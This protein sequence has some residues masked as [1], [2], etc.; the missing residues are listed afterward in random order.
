M[1]S[2][3][4]LLI[5][6]VIGIE[7]SSRGD[8][9]TVLEDDGKVATVTARLAGDGQEFFALERAD[10]RFELVPQARVLKREVGPD[11][12]PISCSTMIERLT[13][14]FGADRFMAH[15]DEPY[16]VGLVFSDPLP[17]AFEPKAATCLKKGA[18]FMKTVEKVFLDFVKDLKIET[19]KPRF[20]L[21]LLIFETDD[22]FIKFAEEET[23]GRGLSGGRM[24]GYYSNL[25]NRL[26]IRM[27]EC[28]T[29]ATPLHEAVHQQVYNRAVIQRLAPVPVWFNEGIA[30]GFEGN[31]EKISGGPFKVSTRFAAAAMQTKN[32]D[33]DDVVADDKAFRGD[34][35]AGE[36]Y[37]N[38]WSIHW[39]LLTKYR[40]QYVEYLKL[41]GQKETLQVETPKA[42]IDD[43]ER[44][45]GKRIGLL[46]S[47]F[48]K[49]LEQQA[50]KQKVSLV[51]EKPP[52]HLLAQIN[53]AEVE[54]TA[55]KDQALN[56]IQAGGRMRN[57][58]QI[59]PMS[60]YVTIESDSGIYAEWYLPNA[61]PRQITPM[62]KQVLAKKIRNAPAGPGRT[63]R[64]NVK[65]AVPD[66]ETGKA[67]QRGEYPVPVWKEN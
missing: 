40:K 30:T 11:P 7:R 54:I 52:G 19:Q 35:L 8:V 38:A 16:V 39:F 27:S 47:E 46:Q 20:P 56:Q 17:K 32:V 49:W 25:T 44:V 21:V 48:P 60:F 29:F 55:V 1:T 66:S 42:R 41:L 61:T 4:L 36:A 13:E 28:H 62:P 31:G 12:E 24:L 5:A 53:L 15:A 33:W 18:A 10:G 45:F 26:V 67:W 57:L 2:K 3:T 65:T 23:G 50:Q 63:F 58:S 34:V 37:A 6:M 59:R 22:D 64:I 51:Q 14:Q 9:F 43:F